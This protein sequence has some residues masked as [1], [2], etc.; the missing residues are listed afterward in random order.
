[1]DS[2]PQ[3]PLAS[4]RPRVAAVLAAWAGAVAVAST[5]GALGRLAPA[6]LAPVIVTSIVVPTVI[7]GR[8]PLLRAAA[9]EVGVYRI[10]LLHTWRV[11]AGVVFLA[12]GV[13]D[14]LP[15]KFVRNAGWGDIIAG[16]FAA[17]LVLLPRKRITYAAFNAV[18]FADFVL[19]FGTGLAATLRRDSRMSAIA[20]FP[21]ALIPLFGVG[22]SGTAHL[23]AFDLLRH[24][25]GSSM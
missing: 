14:K 24:N 1:M 22:V 4:V 19:A 8:S 13:Q 6:T 12:Y 20:T 9:R 21:L 5:T 10:A 15:P 3:S 18:G 25:G 11:A 23:I 16:A 17:A 7:Y 2:N